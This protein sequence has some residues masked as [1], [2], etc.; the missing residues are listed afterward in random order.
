[1]LTLSAV[2]IPKT[3]PPQNVPF[4]MRKTVGLALAAGAALAAIAGLAQHDEKSP[5][6]A[7]PQLPA[8]YLEMDRLE[9]T[10]NTLQSSPIFLKRD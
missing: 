9:A 2:R 7:D 4:T 3:L 1:V 10:A 8:E 5:A 6:L